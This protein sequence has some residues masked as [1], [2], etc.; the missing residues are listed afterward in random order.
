MP[1]CCAGVDQMLL[2]WPREGTACDACILLQVCGRAMCV[3]PALAWD[4]W[5][6]LVE[7]L[8]LEELVHDVVGLVC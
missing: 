6:A 2:G 5:D 3:M 4:H 8:R 7:V 1:C